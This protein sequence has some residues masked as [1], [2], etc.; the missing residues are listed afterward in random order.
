M[1]CGPRPS[2]PSEA[3]R[4]EPLTADTAAT[5][6][7]SMPCEPRRLATG[8]YTRTVLVDATDVYFQME[9][10]VRVVSRGGGPSRT[11]VPDAYEL[12]AVS[13][14][15]LIACRRN[16]SYQSR[17]LAVP[18]AGGPIVD[19]GRTAG[20]DAAVV[21]DS[22]FFAS[23]GKG[24]ERGLSRVALHGGD[25][26][27]LARTP[28]E[29]W[30]V[31]AD[32]EHVFWVV[33]EEIR[34]LDPSTG[35]SLPLA[36]ALEFTGL[37]LSDEYVYWIDA[38]N[39][40]RVP[41]AGGA[42]KVV[43][44]F[45]RSDSDV[46]ASDG[47]RIVWSEGSPSAWY[48]FD[49][50]ASTVATFEAPGRATGLAVDGTEVFWGLLGPRPDIDGGVMV[51]ETCGCDAKALPVRPAM[52]AP[53][54]PGAEDLATLRWGRAAGGELSVEL[55][56]LTADEDALFTMLA[57]KHEEIP[58]NSPGLPARFSVGRRFRAATRA[59]VVEA[60]VSGYFASEGGEG[61]HFFVGM[62]A[63]RAE[64]P[65]VVVDA[66]H[67][68]AMGALRPAR[69]DPRLAK[70]YLPAVQAIV[71]AAE[72]GGTHTLMLEP[73]N[74]TV[75]SGHF[76]PPHTA[77]IAVTAG[78]PPGATDDDLEGVTALLFGDATGAI[79]HTVE[80]LDLRL[81]SYEVSEL[82]DIGKDGT[83]AVVYE[84]RYYE[85]EH[86]MMLEWEDDEPILWGMG[87]DGS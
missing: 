15:H 2:T 73:D 62:D 50:D 60:K 69:P 66:E 78:P 64:G 10:E 51:L 48:R 19:L 67:G 27:V 33:D 43:A 49:P 87:G 1:A 86:T 21:G 22:V 12:A 3:P 47:T 18:K 79:S 40:N 5:P 77:L 17:L 56:D 57:R 83:D 25:A 23:Q 39:L 9:D 68:P 45:P 31:V 82:V 34:R 75:V 74:L 80:T 16:E 54:A 71:D 58:A 35:R 42:A 85:G 38:A 63:P 44:T 65:A 14:S 52:R 29:V 20:C 24:S 76:P 61:L 13:S 32:A 55:V 30:A 26:Q 4:V 72:L 11:V 28:T 70:L 6:A 46:L 37:G 8:G 84:S 81:D 36:M 59:G 53:R 7:C 41:K